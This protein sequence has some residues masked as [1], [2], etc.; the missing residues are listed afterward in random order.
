MVDSRNET[1]FLR[2]S[3]LVDGSSD[4]VLRP[5][6]EWLILQNADVRVA[7]EIA[8]GGP[9]ARD[10]LRSRIEHALENYP[11]DL[12]YVHRDAEIEPHP[13][14][15]VEIETSCSGIDRVVPLVPVRMTEAWLLGNENAIRIAAENKNG[16][17]KLAL[18]A[19]KKIEG[20]PDPKLHLQSLLKSASELSQS[21]LSDQVVRRW[22][23]RVSQVTSDWSHLRGLPSFDDLERR[24]A[25]ALRALRL[26]P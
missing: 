3:L 15:V 1:P 11:C 9:R 6:L 10:G 12:L 25:S 17:V 7:I 16:R 21:R 19:K 14:R 8:K 20:I 18:P 26:G 13:F 23:L 5:I 22:V 4:E 24:T 2:V